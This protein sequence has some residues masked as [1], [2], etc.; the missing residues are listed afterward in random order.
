MVYFWHGKFSRWGKILPPRPLN[1]RSVM[2][3]WNIILPGQ[4]G[5]SVHI[6][7]RPTDIPV[8]ELD[9]DLGLPGWPDSHMNT[10]E[11]LQR[12]QWE[13]REIS[14]TGFIWT[15]AVRTCPSL[16][17]RFLKY[18]GATCPLGCCPLWT[19]RRLS[20][21]GDVPSFATCMGRSVKLWRYSLDQRFQKCRWMRWK[22]RSSLSVSFITTQQFLA[23][24][25]VDAPW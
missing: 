10:S 13:V 8:A 3:G 7:A 1:D 6:W 18:R 9:R 4:P 25:L 17:G 19:R 16:L 15:F 12:K 21:L 5:W 14:I 11:F 2:R 22:Y 24:W 20:P 23:F